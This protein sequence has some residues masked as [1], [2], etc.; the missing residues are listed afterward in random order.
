MSFVFYN[1]NPNG[2]RVIDCS[3]RALSK[4]LDNDWE[5]SYI[6]LCAE[7]FIYKDMP[8]SAYV[9]G[10][11]LKKRGYKQKFIPYICPECTTVSK[12]A[13]EHKVGKFVLV[14][15][16][17]IVAVVDGD[18]YDTWDCGDEIVIYYYMEEL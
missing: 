13:E 4:V 8:S 9:I 17:H 14:T 10:M 1:P 7:G 3:V 5:E 12:F 15:E 18:Y 2:K 16:E 11:Y 6:G